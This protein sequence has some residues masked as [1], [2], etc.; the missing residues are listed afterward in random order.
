MKWYNIVAII[1]GVFFLLGFVE[2]WLRAKK[3]NAKQN[4]LLNFIYISMAI[5][6][7]LIMTCSFLLIGGIYWW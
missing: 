3:L 7:F 2:L 5:V 4:G 6:W 1:N